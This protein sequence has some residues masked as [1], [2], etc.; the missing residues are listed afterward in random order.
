MID[1]LIVEDSALLRRHLAHLLEG[2]GAF[3]VVG[4]VSSGEEACAFLGR[5]VASVVTMDIHMPGMGGFEATRRI[6]ESTPVPIVIVSA[7]WEPE[8]VEETF[9]AMEAGA[10]SI[11]STPKGDVLEGVEEFLNTVRQAAEAQVKRLRPRRRDP[12][13]KEVPELREGPISHGGGTPTSSR[14]ES[15]PFRAVAMGASTG[16]PLA[17]QQILAELPRTFSLPVLMVQHITRGFF[18]GYVRW[19]NETSALPVSLAQE[20]EKTLPGRVYLAPEGYHMGVRT[21]GV[22]V[23]SQDPPEHGVRPSVSWLFRSLIRVYGAATLGVLL[24]GMGADGAEELRMLREKGGVT[25]AQDRESSV[26]WGMP[27]EAVRRGGAVYV[28]PPR[29]IASTLVELVRTSEAR[30]G[31]LTERPGRS[32]GV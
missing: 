17:V 26:V 22:V 32:S 19:L 31:P 3:R 27:G 1:V 28:L 7:C 24:T 11:V 10:V 14:K 5:H 29:S 8:D 6:M 15:P 21:G 23:L 4:Q 9:R 18:E 25:F 16:G 13:P 2:D 12:A 30:K 20:G